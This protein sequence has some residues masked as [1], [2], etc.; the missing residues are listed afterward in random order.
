VDEC[1]EA[2]HS[3]LADVEQCRNTEGAYECD[4]KCGKGF[5]YSIGLGV[6]VG[7]LSFF[8]STIFRKSL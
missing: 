8:I 7:E 6:C 2:I 4:M 5:M 3:C 1:A